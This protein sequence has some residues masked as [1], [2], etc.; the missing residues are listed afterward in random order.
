MLDCSEGDVI[1]SIFTWNYCNCPDRSA[2]SLVGSLLN[3]VFLWVNMNLVL[4]VYVLVRSRLFRFQPNTNLQNLCSLLKG[5][6]SLVTNTTGGGG[7][8]DD[9]PC[10][11]ARPYC[12]HNLNVGL[13]EITDL[14]VF[15]K[16]KVRYLLGELWRG[17]KKGK[18]KG[19]REGGE[20]S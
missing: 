19:K 10:S 5:K 13:Q 7:N 18:R 2:V 9:F 15:F 11:G 8:A 20:R 16:S 1:R 17:R 12:L 3:P 14:R 4:L 6:F